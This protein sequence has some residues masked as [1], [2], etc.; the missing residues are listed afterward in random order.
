MATA[1]FVCHRRNGSL[2]VVPPGPCL[3]E[4]GRHSAAICWELRSGPNRAEVTVQ[5]LMKYFADGVLK[6]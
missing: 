4:T 2:V 3:I 5:Q 1:E 6:Y